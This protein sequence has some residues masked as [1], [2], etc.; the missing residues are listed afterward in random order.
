MPRRAAG[1]DL[2][3]LDTQPADAVLR[4]DDAA[5]ESQLLAL[6]EHLR[7]QV[8]EILLHDA[9]GLVVDVARQLRLGDVAAQLLVLLLERLDL[10]RQLATPLHLGELAVAAREAAPLVNHVQQQQAA[11]HADDRKPPPPPRGLIT[12]HERDR[13]ASIGKTAMRSYT[14]R[15]EPAEIT[16]QAPSGN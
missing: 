11:E 9:V 1:L 5:I 7:L 6:L 4:R 13:C 2:E 3:A 12:N 15:A 14:G 8:F 10:R 16:A